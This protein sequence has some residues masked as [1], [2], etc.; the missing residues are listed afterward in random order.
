[1]EAQFERS[2]GKIDTKNGRTKNTNSKKSGNDGN[3][4]VAKPDAETVYFPGDDS[5]QGFLSWSDEENFMP[6]LFDMSELPE[7]TSIYYIS[8]E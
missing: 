3:G 1:M 4:K 2:D 8:P 6:E 7:G 5:L